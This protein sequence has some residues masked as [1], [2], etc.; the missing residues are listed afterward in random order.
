[1]AATPSLEEC[2]ELMEEMRRIYSTDEDA[3]KVAELKATRAHIAAACA[4]REAHM[5]EL[6]KG[7]PACARLRAGHGEAVDAVRHA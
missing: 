7:A 1:M 2:F 6:I 3:I 5:A 4:A